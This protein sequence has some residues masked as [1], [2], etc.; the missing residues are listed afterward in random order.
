MCGIAGILSAEHGAAE[1]RDRAE[2]MQH[3]LAHRGPDDRAVWI[4]Y[5]ADAV[6]AHNRLAVLDPT[7]AGRQPMSIDAGRLTIN[8]NGEIYNFM[9]LRAELERRGV[10]FRTRTDTEVVLRAYDAYGDRCVERLR[11]MFAFAIWDE[12]ARRCLLARDR[13]G[14]K[15]LYYALRNRRLVFASELRGVM[16]SG[17]I[18]PVVDG[19]AAYEYFRAGSVP[20][21][22]TLVQGVRCIEAGQ[23]AIWRDGGLTLSKYFELSFTP[24]L[25]PVDAAAETRRALADSVAHHFI[26]D[27]PVGI[28]LSGGLDSTAMLALARQSGH[29]DVQALTMAIPGT[30]DD[31][32]ML[33][34]KTARHFGV[35]HH[36][37]HVDGEAARALFSNYLSAMDQPSIDGMNTLAVSQLAQS[38]GL[39]VMLSG[40]GA[41]EL[42]GGYPSVRSV[43]KFDAWNRRLSATGPLRSAAGRLLE[44]L[45]DPRCRR[46]GD[47]LGQAPG[48]AASYASFRGIFT[49]AEAR[50]LT[51]QFVSTPAEDDGVAAEERVDPTP[52]DAAC[53]LEMTRYLRNQ[54]LRD[55]DVMSMACGVEVRVPFLDS[56]VVS[57]V[58]SI[59][60][61]QRLNPGKALLRQAVPEIPDW[62]STQPKRGFMFPMDQWLRGPWQDVFGDTDVR[63]SVPTGTWYRKWCIHAFRIWLH[64]LNRS[65]VVQPFSRVV[66]T[67]RLNG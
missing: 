3:A 60:Q 55:A 62:I 1:L 39:K 56:V 44:R 65:T 20:E 28:F 17:L 15:P 63:S 47:M 35:R 22:Q 5:G 59:P 10:V 48:L 37:R 11:G 12:P 25:Q 64:R 40:V 38:C 52:Q 21:P 42:F 26:S 34:Q 16:A 6:F 30:A 43:P 31:E 54:L 29:R 32:M 8:F 41:D 33:A 45:P 51:R 14:I 24:A 58:T 46:I 50:A 57:T 61:H 23:L 18:D 4:S 19:S 36:V 2:A 66:A 9:E 7:P 27:V 49:R 67:P 13:F 53:R